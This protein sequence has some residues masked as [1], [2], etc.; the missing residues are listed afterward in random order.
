MDDAPLDRFNH[1][2]IAYMRDYLSKVVQKRPIEN[3]NICIYDII[4]LCNNNTVLNNH[5]IIY[6]LEELLS[7]NNKDKIRIYHHNLLQ[8]SSFYRDMKQRTVQSLED[9]LLAL[10]TDGYQNFLSIACQ[11]I[12]GEFITSNNQKQITILKTVHYFVFTIYRNQD[13]INVYITDSTYNNG[14][15]LQTELVKYVDNI[16]LPP[17][18]RQKDGYT[19]SVF[20]IL[21]AKILWKYM[22]DDRFLLYA[23]SLSFPPEMMIYCQNSEAFMQYTEVIPVSNNIKNK[24]MANIVAGKNMYC[25]KFIENIY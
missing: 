19:C 10:Q 23:Y 22:V 15:A 3:A 2:K 6:N 14:K 16:Y 11:T 8:L 25:A 5:Y 1:I 24:Y 13:E 18:T 21:D 12:M 9:Y 7:C 20:A 4:E 17:I